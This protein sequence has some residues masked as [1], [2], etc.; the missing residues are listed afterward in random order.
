MSAPMIRTNTPGIFRRGS[1][2]VYTWR[3]QNGKLRRRSAATMAEAKARR[4]VE[5]DRVRR[6][7]R[8]ADTSVTFVDYAKRWIEGYTGRTVR[9][10]NDDTRADYRKALGLDTQ[11]NVVGGACAFFGTR[12]LS[13]IGPADIRAYAG[14]VAQRGLAR[15]TV[16]LALAPV[17]A[18]L[19]QAHE[20]EVIGGI[21]RQGCGIFCRRR[22]RRG[23][24]STFA[25]STRRS[26]R[27]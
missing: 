6:G 12:R 21:P 9:G 26:T 25:R 18:M 14:E 5:L 4:G 17:K 3:D 24:T 22:G 8:V 7:E 16:R 15:N 2:Y 1:R 23:R 20:D 27:R 19:A 13:S 10:I 11:G